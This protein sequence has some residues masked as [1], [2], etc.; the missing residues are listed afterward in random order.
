MFRLLSRLRE[1][2][3]ILCIGLLLGLL[4]SLQSVGLLQGLQEWLTFPM[5]MQE[6]EMVRAAASVMPC[7]TIGIA[8]Q[9]VIAA[10]ISWNVR[11]AHEKESRR[12]WWSYWLSPFWWNDVPLI[13]MPCAII[14]ERS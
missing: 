2:P 3:L 8:Y 4:P 1:N 7:S 13:P 11:I 9:P 10:V 12:H 6:V 14:R 5:L